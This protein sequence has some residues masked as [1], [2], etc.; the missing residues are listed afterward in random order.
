M[1][2]APP[3]TQGDI[4]VPLRA[5]LDECP[6]LGRKGGTSWNKG[7][8]ATPESRK[9]QSEALRGKPQPWDHRNHTTPHTPETREKMR[10][11]R[12]EW[13]ARRRG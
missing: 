6:K 12:R 1:K 2:L 9:K 10:Q 11:I 4:A 3:G 13:W 5:A 7:I 8:P